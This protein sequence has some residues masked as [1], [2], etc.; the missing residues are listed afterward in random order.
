M[1]LP[2]TIHAHRDGPEATLVMSGELDVAAA[3]LV[4]DAVIGLCADGT[5]RLLIDIEGISFMDS[6]GL[7]SLLASRDLCESHECELL[8]TRGGEQVRRLFEL[9]GLVD[10]LPFVAGPREPGGRPA[11]GR[12]GATVERPPETEDVLGG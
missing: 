8:V 9:T 6:T 7:R 2:F 1:T 5:S 11:R 10:R 12:P 4:A 3:P